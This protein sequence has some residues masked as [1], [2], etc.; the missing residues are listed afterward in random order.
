M[1]EKNLPEIQSSKIDYV[2]V[3]AEELPP[4]RK[5]WW[6]R[7]QT[8]VIGLALGMVLTVAAFVYGLDIPSANRPIPEG[9]LPVS[10]VHSTK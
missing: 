10:P 9:G 5:H 1:G 8:F 3:F 2:D 6:N 7:R 4:E